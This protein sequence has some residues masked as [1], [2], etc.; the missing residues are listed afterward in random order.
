ME[1]L[2]ACQA[3]CQECQACQAILGHGQGCLASQWAVLCPPRQKKTRI[4][5]KTR[6]ARRRSQAGRSSGR[7]ASVIVILEVPVEGALSAAS[8]RR[9]AKEGA[10]P[11]AAALAAARGGARAAARAPSAALLRGRQDLG[12][13]H[14]VRRRLNLSAGASHQA[15]SRTSSTGQRWLELLQP[16]QR[17][18]AAHPR[19]R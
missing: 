11:A 3:T 9:S 7:E 1:C 18:L 12:A 10:H 5:K 14:A 19:D 6:M 2:T 4:P 15:M 16:W 8:A 17:W 13:S